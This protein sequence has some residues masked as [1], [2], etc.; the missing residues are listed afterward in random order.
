MR[1]ARKGDSVR[2]H[3]FCR[4]QDGTPVETTLQGPPAEICLGE[5][6]LLP[7]VESAIVGMRP[8]EHKHIHLPPVR[9]FGPRRPE[10]VRDVP[11]KRLALDIEP[12]PGMLVEVLPDGDDGRWQ[13]LIVE[14]LGD[15]AV[16]VDGNHPLAGETLQY[17]ITCVEFVE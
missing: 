5:G 1:A 7:A 2:V 4:R 16:T 12:Q 15:D 9:A 14:L 8:G 13:G 17:D 6:L 11:R 3:Y 10:L